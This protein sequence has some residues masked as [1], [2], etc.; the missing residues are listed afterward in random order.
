M[1]SPMA[2]REEV[3]LAFHL[4][5]TSPIFS[6]YKSSFYLVTGPLGK[7]L[8]LDLV[9][10]SRANPTFVLDTLLKALCNVRCIYC[11]TFP[12]VSII[13]WEM[14]LCGKIG[15]CVSLLGLL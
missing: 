15:G 8:K 10:F 6:P 7:T 9:K 11:N 2:E 14:H 12:M 5:W 13:I 4:L 1:S 3:A